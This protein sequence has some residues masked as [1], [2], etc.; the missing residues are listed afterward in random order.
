MQKKRTVALLPMKANSERVRGKNFR[1]FNGKPLFRWILDTLLS[2]EAIDAPDA[3]IPIRTLRNIDSNPNF[4]GEIMVLSLGCEKLQPERLL[5]PGSIP[6]A[7][8]RG[9][10]LDVELA[11]LVIDDIGGEGQ[12]VRLLQY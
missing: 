7:D 11:D 9:E 5:P 6:I 10:T 12:R 3:I 4:G 8:Q 2:I 1:L